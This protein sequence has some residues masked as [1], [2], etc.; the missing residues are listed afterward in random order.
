MPIRSHFS[1]G[2]GKAVAIL[3]YQGINESCVPNQDYMYRACA[4]IDEETGK[5]MEYRDLLKDPKQG[6]TWPRA[7]A[8]EFGRLF[9]GVGK[10]ADGTQR[11]KGTNT[12]HWIKKSQVP[13]GKRV[14]YARTVVAV[15][16]EKEEIN[17]VRITVGGNL[18]DYLGETSTEAA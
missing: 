15:S 12:C 9:D 1:N 2:Y 16:P 11:V 13:K 5:S 6:E 3:E 7:A 18:L 4:V 14:T 10:N 8:N 17:R